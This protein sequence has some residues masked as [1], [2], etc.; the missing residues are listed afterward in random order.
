MQALAPKSW[1][2]MA[3]RRAGKIAGKS[4]RESSEQKIVKLYVNY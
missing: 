2:A 1:Q 4:E 3:P